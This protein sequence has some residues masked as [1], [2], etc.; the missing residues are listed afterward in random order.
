MVFSA[1][2]RVKFYLKG[3]VIA[4]YTTATPIHSRIKLI[5]NESCPGDVSYM[6]YVSLVTLP[7]EFP[8]WQ[9]C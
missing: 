2:L 4:V 5:V 6:S 7:L 3:T 1:L 9:T 8:T